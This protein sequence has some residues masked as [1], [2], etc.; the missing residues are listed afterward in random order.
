MTA[1]SRFL[2]TLAL[3]AA[4]P[5]LSACE[6]TK[7]NLGLTRR[8][9]DEFAVIKRAPLEV[10]QD[11]SSLPTPMPGARRPQE[12][13]PGVLARETLVGPDTAA[14]Q[15]VAPSAAESALLAKTGG[16]A[17]SP[18]IRR[19]VN[20]EAEENTQDN[21][22]VVKKLLDLG[23][24]DAQSPATIVDAPAELER[25]QTNKQTGQP[26]TKGETPTLDD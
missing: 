25:L 6:Q 7:E 18:A 5:L 15:P 13:S 26:L 19:Q 22:P 12:V 23:K 11:L 14:Q 21:R 1:R 4:L 17:A 10:P 3:F 16:V 9:P 20:R 2:F 8:T 24:S